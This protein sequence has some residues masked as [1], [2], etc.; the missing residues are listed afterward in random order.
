MSFEEAQEVFDD[1]QS[2]TEPD[3][4]HSIYEVRYQTV[5]HMLSER[6]LIVFHTFDA[7]ADKGRIF[8]ARDP[9]PHERRQY[10]NKP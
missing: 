6:L 3:W 9:E 10:E 4:E 8:S 5:G 7:E 2:A 1:P